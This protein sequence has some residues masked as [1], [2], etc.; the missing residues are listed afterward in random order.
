MSSTIKRIKNKQSLLNQSRLKQIR[1]DL[2]ARSGTETI[3]PALERLIEAEQNEQARLA[4]SK[5]IKAAIRDNLH[6]EDVFGR[7]AEK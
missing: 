7:L 6:I 4:Q 1:H 5:F 2:G 3:A